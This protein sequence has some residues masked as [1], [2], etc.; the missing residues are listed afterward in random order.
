MTFG[1]YNILLAVGCLTTEYP[2]ARV[3]QI[4]YQAPCKP[5][6]SW[7]GTSHMV[8]S[9][10]TVVA[11]LIILMIND[12]LHQRM[13]RLEINNI[14]TKT[15]LRSL[16]PMTDLSSSSWVIAKHLGFK[17]V[18]FFSLLIMEATLFVLL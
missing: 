4:L 17:E 15:V 11:Y 14:F 9:S 8:G 2:G 12:K 10:H 6:L 1:W 5:F 16:G 7:R 18:C 3:Q 13:L